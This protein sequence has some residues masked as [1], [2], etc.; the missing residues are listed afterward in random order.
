MDRLRVIY[1]I[2]AYDVLHLVPAEE[3][4]K[5]TL[6]YSEK[7]FLFG[8]LDIMGVNVTKHNSRY[9]IRAVRSRVAPSRPRQ[10]HS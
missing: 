9:K 5:I 1:V 8:W 10:I 6:D 4:H 3:Y 2:S 7:I